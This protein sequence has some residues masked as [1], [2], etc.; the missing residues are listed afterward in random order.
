[1][2]ILITT[3]YFSN[4]GGSELETIHTANAFADFDFVKFVYIYVD[5]NINLDFIEEILISKKVKILN[6]KMYSKRIWLKLDKLIFRIFKIKFQFFYSIFCFFLLLKGFNRVYIITKSSLDYYLPIIRFFKNK[7]NI[8][9][10]YTT[11]FYESFSL[12]KI[13]SLNKIRNNLVTCESQ[14]LFFI[15]NLKIKNT[16]IEEVILFNED[17]ALI[18]NRESFHRNLFDFGI[19]GRF[20]EEKKI[21]DAILLIDNLK[22]NNIIATLVIIGHGSACYFESLQ[23]MV[24]IKQLEN[25]VQLIFT[26]V[27]YNL[28]YDIFDTFNFLLITSNYE[29]GPNIGLEA[30]ALGIPVLSY[31]VGA[32]PDR[33]NQFSNLLI[34]KNFQELLDKSINLISLK[35]LEY[36]KLCQLIKGEYKRKYCNR[37]KIEY[38]KNFIMNNSSS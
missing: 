27:E 4:L 25:Q 16:K 36:V 22:N 14:K 19:I 2:K 13:E 31:N 28:V 9:I 21:E 34:A 1:M 8:V 12:E 33:L 11:I 30:M 3:P 38:L 17:Y 15:N 6:S 23:N 29:G 7:N 18:K 37:I 20:S 32:M 5:G 24:K 35:E 10:K 26:K